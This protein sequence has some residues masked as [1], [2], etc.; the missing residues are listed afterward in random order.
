LLIETILGEIVRA[1]VRLADP[2]EFTKRAFLN[3]RIDLSQAK[4]TADMIMARSRRR[5]ELALSHFKGDL[6]RKIE[7][8]HCSLLD[9]LAALEVSIDF[10]EEDDGGAGTP[11]VTGLGAV[12]AD[13]VSRRGS[14]IIRICPRKPWRPPQS[15][16]QCVRNWRNSSGTNP[17]SLNFFIRPDDLR[18]LRFV[19]R[20]GLLHENVFARLQGL[21]NEPGV[22]MVPHQDENRLN[23]RVIQN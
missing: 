20:Q 5:R 11:P 6:A 18:Q 4:A 23:P 9:V 7:T 12:I 21:A 13:I 3:N 16:R 10:M 17:S 19:D 14:V 8:L 15:L 2:G 1:G 22:E